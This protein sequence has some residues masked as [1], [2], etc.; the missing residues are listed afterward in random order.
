MTRKMKALIKARSEPGLV[1][2]EVDVPT[3]GPDEVLIQVLATTICGSDVHI[4]RWDDWAQRN[5]RPP[6]IIGHEVAGRV[7]A[8]G[9]HVE[10]WKE[11]DYVSVETHIV[12]GRCRACRTGNM[13][14]CY[15]LQI[16]GVHRPGSYAEYVCVPAMNLV[17]NDPRWHPAVASIQEPFGNAVDTVLCEPVAG[18]R[19]LVTGCGPIGLMAIGVARAAGADWVGATDPNAFRRSL[20]LQMGAD[21][22]WDPTREPV[23][24][25]IMEATQGEGVDVVLEM[26]GHPAALDLGLKALAMA[27]RVA[28]LGLLP[29]PVSTDLTDGLIFKGARMYGITGRH[30]F[31]TWYQVQAFLRDGKVPLERL[32]THEYPLEAFEAAFRQME[33]GDCAKVALYPNLELVRPLHGLASA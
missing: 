7:V 28:L 12:C 10:A 1:L 8:V 23:L 11:G 20:A 4:Y 32:I 25:L 15:R 30:M 6:L 3:P 24:D 5:I 27:G 14:V 17:R 2:D 13:H 21:R 31:R 16:L 19:V 22:V 33:A 9:R 26:S 18:A 29:T